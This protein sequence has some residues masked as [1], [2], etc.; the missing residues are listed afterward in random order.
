MPK[1]SQVSYRNLKGVNEQLIILVEKAIISTPVDFRVTDGLR[2]I[3]E[4][5]H[6]VAIGASKTMNSKH[7]TG[8]AI[9]IVPWINGKPR[10]EWPLI[11]KLA[12][13]IRTV[14]QE[15]NIRIRWGAL[16]DVHSFTSTV[17]KP[18]ELVES[19]VARC[20]KVG[21]RVFL[22]GPHYELVNKTEKA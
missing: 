1:L 22:D 13:Y 4:Q 7:L 9:D 14:A 19:Y 18:Q 8:R 21:K 10:W 15:Q 11:Y 2:T 16:W 5:K 12:E 3:E 17:S 20:K 6:L